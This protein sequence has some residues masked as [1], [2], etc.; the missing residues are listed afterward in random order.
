MSPGLYEIT[1]S[2]ARFVADSRIN[3]GLLTAFC[4]H[5]SCSLLLQENADPDVK[6]DLM[7]FF[8]RLAPEGMDWNDDGVLSGEELRPSPWPSARWRRAIRRCPGDRW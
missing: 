6:T 7:G 4:R 2:L 1:D 5:T 8:R 3:E